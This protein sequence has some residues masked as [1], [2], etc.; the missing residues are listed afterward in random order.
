METS[1]DLPPPA[2]SNPSIAGRPGSADG[3][4]SWNLIVNVVVSP[5]LIVSRSSEVVKPGAA[6]AAKDA[7]KKRLN[8]KC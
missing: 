6:W 2:N 8:A 3:A 4:Q 7:A 1:S 5:R